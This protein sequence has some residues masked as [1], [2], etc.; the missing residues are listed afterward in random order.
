MDIFIYD[1]YDLIE[2]RTWD[3]FEVPL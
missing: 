2:M 3:N 1:V